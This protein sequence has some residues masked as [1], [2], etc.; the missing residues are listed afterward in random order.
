LPR[1]AI[2]ALKRASGISLRAVLASRSVVR[3]AL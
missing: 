1:W 2:S 3:E